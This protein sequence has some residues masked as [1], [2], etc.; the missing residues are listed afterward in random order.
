MRM[1]KFFV[2][3]ISFIIAV[4]IPFSAVSLSASD[5]DISSHLAIFASV[6]TLA[7]IASAG[8]ISPDDSYLIE[9]FPYQ[10]QTVS[11]Y[12][13]I[14]PSTG[15]A[16]IF[17]ADDSGKIIYK[18][19]NLECN[20]FLPGSLTQA[21]IAVDA[22]GSRDVNGD[23]LRDILLITRCDYG[24]IRFKI[25]DILYQNKNGF[26]RD[27]R[28]SDKL[29]RFDMNKTDLAVAAF[30]RD[31]VSMEFL[32]TAKT[33]DEL[34]A[35]G[36][37]IISTQRFSE[38]L[39]KFGVVDVVPG[40]FNMAGQNY[41]MVYVVDSTGRI[42]WNFQPM[43][44]YV[45]FYSIS[46]VSFMDIDGDGNKDFTILARY[47][48]YGADGATVIVQDYDIFYQRAGYFLEDTKV[49]QAYT[50]GDTDSIG[51]ITKKARQVWG[52]AT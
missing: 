31:G 16:A 27:P 20:Y 47:V 35:N 42:L 18:T 8:Y 32:F 49:K 10:N 3:L 46:A 51:T 50:C 29:N 41:L 9:N 4:T 19:E 40:F 2:F 13:A 36:F 37:Q 6:S 28:V 23:G 24:G 17:L 43:H 45:N 21:N 39:E 12:S 52:W 38:H 7:D 33:L 34:T 48:T 1:K 5:A 26:Y 30:V 44:Y 11:V 22:I 15:R 25:G 14:Q